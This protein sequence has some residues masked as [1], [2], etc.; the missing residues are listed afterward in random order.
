[1]HLV[2]VLGPVELGDDDSGTGGKAREESDEEVDTTAVPPL[3]AA[4]ASLP[5][6]FPTMMASAVLYRV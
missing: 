5:R 4:R 6:K 2:L 3:T 1:M